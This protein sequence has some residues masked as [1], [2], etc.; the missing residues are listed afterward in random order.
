MGIE[1]ASASPE[2]APV[3]PPDHERIP[4]AVEQ[5]T[6]SKRRTGRTPPGRITP[7]GRRSGSIPSSAITAAVVMVVVPV[8]VVGIAVFSTSRRPHDPL[9]EWVA[10]SAQA[11]P[12]RAVL[13]PD[14]TVGGAPV[15]IV[16][17]E[18][19]RIVGRNASDPDPSLWTFPLVSVGL[20]GSTL[21]DTVLWVPQSG[22]FAV[23]HSGGDPAALLVL[24]KGG[25]SP[26]SVRLTLLS[27]SGRTLWS[28]TLDPNTTPMKLHWL[29]PRDGKLT[30]AAIGSDG[31]TTLL[32]IDT[33]KPAP[34]AP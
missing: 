12:D 34:P 23:A 15:V 2:A 27:T 4:S 16:T 17:R 11:S 6:P 31:R 3:A 22:P 9:L 13:R 7:P 14:A 8:A 32:T 29:E 18:N 25:G 28:A 1:P 33:T 30:L 24:W 20:L 19:Y 5:P 10:A 21:D 26:P